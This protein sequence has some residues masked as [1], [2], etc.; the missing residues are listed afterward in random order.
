MATCNEKHHPDHS[1]THGP[2]CGHTAICHESDVDYLDDGH[3]H[4]MHGDHVDEHAIGVN[5][6]NPV[7]CRPQVHCSHVHGPN[8][9]HKAVP[10]GDHIDYLVDSRLHHLHGDHCDDHVGPR[11]STTVVEPHGL[12]A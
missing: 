5:A 7:K 9:G 2:N 1:H 11:A 8:C 4:R 10:H 12:A 3:L 6:T